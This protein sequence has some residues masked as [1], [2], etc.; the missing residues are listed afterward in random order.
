VRF[1]DPNP[2]TG[3]ASTK[4]LLEASELPTAIFVSSDVLAFAAL[5]AIREHGLRIPDDISVVGFDDHP[6]AQFAYPPLTTVRL[7][8]NE[9]GR[10]AGNMLL[11]LLKHNDEPGRE[12]EL[13]TELI[14]R[15]SSARRL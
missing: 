9:M 1:G 13:E 15:A 8:F 11:N 4:S 3:F 14:I 5:A 10:Q 12:I 7:P 6:L 2:G